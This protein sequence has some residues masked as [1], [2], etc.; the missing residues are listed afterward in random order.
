MQIG[1]KTIS[2]LSAVFV[3]NFIKPKQRRLVNLIRRD[4]LAKSANC[5]A[6]TVNEEKTKRFDANSFITRHQNIQVV[7]EMFFESIILV[8]YEICDTRSL[9]YV[10]LSKHQT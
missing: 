5:L 1:K 9:V 8:V 3:Q 4:C 10:Q 7:A 2:V 6:S